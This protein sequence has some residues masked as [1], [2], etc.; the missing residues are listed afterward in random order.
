MI[1]AYDEILLNRACDMLGIMLDYSAHSLHISTEEMLKLF[2]ASGAASLFER[3]DIRTIL[4]RSG[5]EL[6]Y[7]VL[8][9]S[10]VPYERTAPRHTISQS[11]EYRYGYDLARRQ[12]EQGLSFDELLAAAAD[13]TPRQSA[14]QKIRKQNCLSQ[15]ALAKASGVPL[16]TIQ[17]YEQRRKDINKARSEYLIM[18]SQTLNCSPSALLEK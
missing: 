7:E 14:L 6:A 2:I 18:L 15:S 17:Q 4:G 10:G 3:G 12:H 1:R 16:R 8:E 11:E 5:I 13:G 9:R